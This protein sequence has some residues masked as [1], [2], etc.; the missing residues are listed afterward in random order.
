MAGVFSST[1]AGLSVTPIVTGAAG[2]EIEVDGTHVFWRNPSGNILKTSTA[3]GSSTTIFSSPSRTFALSSDAVYVVT[4]YPTS[5]IWRAL[6]AGA[7]PE[8]VATGQ[9]EVVDIIADNAHVYWTVPG[10]PNAGSIMRL[11]LAGGTPELFINAIT[12]PQYLALDDK[13]VYWTSPGSGGEKGGV[14]KVAK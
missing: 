11:K 13:A 10:G 8:K 2:D 12:L 9:K 14:F 6:K 7:V 3:G 4:G 1:L 5:D